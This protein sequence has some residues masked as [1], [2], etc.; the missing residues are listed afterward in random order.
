MKR[1][2][3]VVLKFGGSVLRDETTLRL[4]ALEIRRWR[5]DGH[6][7]V[8]V[9]SAL[10]G[11]TDDLFAKCRRLCQSP[12]PESVATVVGLGEMQSAA[13]LG[14]HLDCEGV[15]A[16]VLSPAA[17]RLIATGDPLDATPTELDAGI[18]NRAI[19]REGVVVV[20]GYV[21][22]DQAGRMVVLGRGGSDLTALFLADRLAA[23]R[24]RL[25]KDVDG[26]YERDPAG[27][28][29]APRR[30]VVATWG[31]ALATDG[32][33]IQHKAIGFAQLHGIEFEL[34]GLS[35]SSPTRIGPGPTRFDQ[36]PSLPD[37]I[38]VAV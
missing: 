16:C 3:L 24:C 18:V 32:A 9:V 4:A 28:G 36:K 25:I 8:A 22:T 7:V 14:L 35:G 12:R 11:T 15:P 10:A 1:S 26:L 19:D 31:D 30:F 6:R 29:P 37:R 20:P 5:R 2:P 34:G 33:I 21:A 27:V 38:A 13:L 23:D 17:I